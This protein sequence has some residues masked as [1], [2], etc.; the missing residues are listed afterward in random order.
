MTLQRESVP[1]WPPIGPQ[2]APKALPNNI[3][4]SNNFY[5][6]NT[7]RALPPSA[8]DPHGKIV[9]LPGQDALGVY[10]QRVIV[11]PIYGDSGEVDFNSA[12]SVTD[13]DRG[14]PI[15]L[16]AHTDNHL[17]RQ[18]DGSLIAIKSSYYWKQLPN[19]KPWQQLPLPDNRGTP[20]LTENGARGA[21]VVW[22]GTRLGGGGPLPLGGLLFWEL[23]GAADPFV[24]S[25][26]YSGSDR[27]ELYA[28]PF[29]GNLYLTAEFYPSKNATGPRPDPYGIRLVYSTDQGKSWHLVDTGTDLDGVPPMVI[30]STPNGRLFLYHWV[31][32]PAAGFTGPSYYGELFCSDIVMPGEVPKIHR[33]LPASAGGQQIYDGTTKTYLSLE[34]NG[35]LSYF[36]DVIINPTDPSLG[37]I[38]PDNIPP[39]P[40]LLKKGVNP[41][42]TPAISRASID[43]N[44]SRVRVA[45][46]ALN[47]YN[48]Q[49]VGIVDIE[50]T[51]TSN[52]PR[53]ETGHLRLAGRVKAKDAT[54]HSVLHGTFIDPDYIDT[55]MGFVSNTSMFYWLDWPALPASDMSA[56]YCL[57]S[58]WP[59]HLSATKPLSVSDG[60]PRS[61]ASSDPGGDYLSGGFFWHNGLNYVP[62]WC[63]LAPGA[64]GIRANIVNIPPP[65]VPPMPLP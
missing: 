17:A 6:E 13:L 60:A 29:T 44:S 1:P 28:C 49:V 64:I 15:F 47:G 14:D 10:L 40:D 2:P 5:W 38:F 39:D 20:P 53:I 26:N 19:A 3:A 51:D 34:A 56:S 22:R 11:R 65:I 48:R 59:S 57:V 45:V 18:K 55:P 58:G 16:G 9:I 30:T 42:P 8:A 32:Q 25:T 27:P 62:Q 33:V 36:E 54:A 52:G 63:E 24:F 12:S 61:W 43:G 31:A 37:Y 50:V 23:Q 7:C 46:P 21:Q 4:V 41:I 35:R